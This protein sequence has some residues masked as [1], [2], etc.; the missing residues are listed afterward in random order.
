MKFK[1]H[2]IK[3]KLH[4]NTTGFTLPEILVSLSL[5]VLIIFL[6]NSVYVLSQRAYNKN[7]DTAELT[8]NVRVSLDRISR[9]IRQS[10]NIVTELPAT[11]DDP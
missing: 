1:K 10:T 3:E 8:Q 4:K 9:E 5:F 7:S 2:S 6:V 11:R